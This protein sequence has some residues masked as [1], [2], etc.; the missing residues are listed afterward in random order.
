MTPT[1]TTTPGESVTVATS[2]LR[3]VLPSG[4]PFYRPME[5]VGAHKRRRKYEERM[6]L[7]PPA[8]EG[9]GGT[10]L[11]RTAT[12]YHVACGQCEGTGLAAVRV[13]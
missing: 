3:D 5:H 10:G 12:R 6:V 4:M 2:D 1:P 11:A 13:R 9:C 7:W 8:C